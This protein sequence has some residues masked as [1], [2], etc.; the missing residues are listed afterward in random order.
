[1][2]GHNGDEGVAYPILPDEEAFEC[3][4][5]PLLKARGEYLLHVD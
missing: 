3:K 4:S 1:M 5:E 2:L